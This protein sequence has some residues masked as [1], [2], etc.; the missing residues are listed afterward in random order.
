MSEAPGADDDDLA[1]SEDHREA[2]YDFIGSLHDGHSFLGS[3]PGAVCR[4]CEN[5]SDVGLALLEEVANEARASVSEVAASIADQIVDETLRQ[6]DILRDQGELRALSWVM[7]DMVARYGYE[8]ATGN[9]I[10]KSLESQVERI[11]KKLAEE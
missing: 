2:L 10:Y 8:G 3:D 5:V 4:A 11:R 1:I 6:A 7:I 9:E